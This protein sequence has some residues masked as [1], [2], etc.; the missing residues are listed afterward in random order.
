M[1]Y[2]SVAHYLIQSRRSQG[3]VEADSAIASPA[4]A[5]SSEPFSDIEAAAKQS[6]QVSVKQAESSSPLSEVEID[7]E[8]TDLND[9]EMLST[10]EPATY[11]RA[12]RSLHFSGS[13]TPPDNK[14]SAEFS[15]NIHKDLVQS[16]NFK[17]IGEE[18]DEIKGLVK[19][20]LHSK[21]KES[22]D[23][24]ISSE[25][26]LKLKRRALLYSTSPDSIAARL[27]QRRRIA[28]GY[29][30]VELTVVTKKTSVVQQTFLSSNQVM[31][32]EEEDD[33]QADRTM[34]FENTRKVNEMDKE[35]ADEQKSDDRASENA[36]GGEELGG[37]KKLGALAGQYGIARRLR[38]RHKTT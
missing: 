32:I 18:V 1:G 27:R 16:N 36:Y 9:K 6:L 29:N 19:E 26:S 22:D 14:T 23:K 24:N 21:N 38:P 13:E 7:H 20:K 17:V 3:V 25:S 11:G 8:S 10:G 5:K 37:D 28:N 15:H 33:K 30:E 34:A 31:E 4:S 12:K 35:Q 2:K